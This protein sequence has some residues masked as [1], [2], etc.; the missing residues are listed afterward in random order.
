M[1]SILL[2]ELVVLCCSGSFYNPTAARDTTYFV[3]QEIHDE[4]HRKMSS[5]AE[6]AEQLEMVPDE[7]ESYDWQA[8]REYIMEIIIPICSCGLATG[9]ALG[10]VLTSLFLNFVISPKTIKE[11]I[12]L[13]PTT[14]TPR[15]YFAY[16]PPAN[17]C[18]TRS[19]SMMSNLLQSML[20]EHVEP[21]DDFYEYVC[22]R[23]DAPEENMHKTLEMDVKKAARE[24][25]E[26]IVV[27]KTGQTPEQKSVALLRA[28]KATRTNNVNNPA[29]LL[30]F[31]AQQQMSSSGSDTTTDGLDRLFG[32]SLHYGLHVLFETGVPSTGDLTASGQ[33]ML[34]LRWNADYKA[35]ISRSPQVDVH[36]YNKRLSAFGVDTSL[37]QAIKGSETTVGKAMQSVDAESETQVP[38]A[39]KDMD[40]GARGGGPWLSILKK[41]ASPHYTVEDQVWTSEKLLKFLNTVLAGLRNDQINL[42]ALWELIRQF[43]P[44][45][46]NEL[47]DDYDDSTY[48]TRCDK[49]LDA[50]ASMSFYHIHNI[51]DPVALRSVGSLASD[52]QNGLLEWLSTSTLVDKEASLDDVAKVNFVLGFPEGLQTKRD[53]ETF[54]SV[55]PNIGESFLGAWLRKRE[56]WITW[57][58]NHPGIFLF[59]LFG[60][61]LPFNKISHVVGVPA[62]VLHNFLFREDLLAAVNYASLGHLIATAL[63]EGFVTFKPSNTACKQTSRL[64]GLH[65]AHKAYLQNSAEQ[66]MRL[67]VLRLSS[68]KLFFVSACL[69]TCASRGVDGA[70]RNADCHDLVENMQ[71]FAETFE[72]VPDSSMNPS[73]KC[74]LSRRL[75]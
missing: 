53:L 1:C 20:S 63:I 38:K 25:A 13:K 3:A 45:V 68:R 72:C 11:L 29:D 32:L 10:A 28:C 2:E 41:Y 58:L 74:D 6:S 42:L 23:Y 37:Q 5:N 62:T 54:W 73:K 43:G 21:C 55:V 18:F 69:K 34:H 9:I 36:Y 48:S 7:E 15:T 27:P 44:F 57:K 51:V 64:L 67:P 33:R 12:G 4:V 49:M 40:P 56:S 59:P 50:A 65:I 46:N 16:T 14:T 26:A 31:M 71:S 60:N 24:W 66:A 61:E 30:G 75:G 47:S 35:W 19:C 52:V 17:V 22:G 39:I 8:L 70:E